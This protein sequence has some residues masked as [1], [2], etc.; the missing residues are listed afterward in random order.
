MFDVFT[1]AALTVSVITGHT[2]SVIHISIIL[3]K[4][5]FNTPEILLLLYF[6]LHPSA[7]QSKLIHNGLEIA[8]EVE[9]VILDQQREVHIFAKPL[10]TMKHTQA[11]AAIERRL[12]KETAL[13]KPGKDYLLISL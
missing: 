4:S 7:H 6:Y 5:R 11:C 3:Q 13:G 12:I 1:L 9:P 2:A 10:Q 8:G